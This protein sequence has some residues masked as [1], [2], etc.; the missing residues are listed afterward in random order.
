MTVYS[1]VQD[2]GDNLVYVGVGANLG[3]PMQ[4]ILD[5]KARLN[6]SQLARTTSTS[7]RFYSAPVGYDDQP[8]F[9]NAV[10]CMVTSL[11]PLPFLNWLQSIE[12]ELGRK[13]DPR[14]RNAPRTLDLDILLF[15]QESIQQTQLIVPHPRMHERRFVLEP[16]LEILPKSDHR[17]ARL[18]GYNAELKR[19]NSQVVYRLEC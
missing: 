4:Q 2:L 19:D 11:A 17:F 1:A 8:Y 3:D 14:Q 6:G 5:A 13:R 7:S 10:F 12:D 18:Q 9:I 15:A 16:L